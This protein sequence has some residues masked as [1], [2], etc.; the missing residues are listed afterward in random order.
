MKFERG[1][2]CGFGINDVPELTFVKDEN[3]KAELTQAYKTWTGIIDR[4]YRPGHEEK[5]KAYADCSVCEEW[6]Y[7]S[8]FKKWF[9]ENYIEGFDIDKDSAEISIEGKIKLIGY[10]KDVDSA[11]E[12]YNQARK[13]YILEIAEKYKDKLKPNVY[14]AIKRLG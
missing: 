14:E 7:F 3:G 8:N 6:K 11:A 1:T 9:D 12:A 4:C 13:E 2:I 10:F 5:F